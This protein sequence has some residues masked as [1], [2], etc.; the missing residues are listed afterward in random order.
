MQ[1]NARMTNQETEELEIDKAY[2]VP[3]GADILWRATKSGR[4][5]MVVESAKSVDPDKKP[6][7]MKD[8]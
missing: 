6:A 8:G 5:V 2:M 4:L 7:T 1:G 3:R